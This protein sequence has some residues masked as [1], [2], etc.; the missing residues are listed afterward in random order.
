M[1]VS[2]LKKENDSLKHEITALKRNLEELQQSI[3]R[4]DPQVTSNG[5]EQ[6]THLITDAESLSTLEFYGKSYDDLWAESVN[7]LKHLWSRL[8]LMSSR[9]GKIGDLIEQLQRY[10]RMNR[11]SKLPPCISIFSKPLELKFQ[12]K[13]SILP[14]VSLPDLPLLALD[15]L[16]AN[17]QEDLW[18]SKKA[19]ANTIGL[20]S[21]GTFHSTKNSGMKFQVFHVTNGT[22]FSGWFEPSCPSPSR[23]NFRV[24]I[25]NKQG[26][27]IMADSLSILLALEL[28]N[29]YEVEISEV[30]DEDDDI[31]LF[32]VG[33]SYMRRNLN[34]V[35]DYFEG[36]IPLYF[37]YEFKGHFRMTRETC[38]LFTRAV[39]PTGRI[40]LGNGSG[41]AAIPPPKQV[42]AFLWCMANQEPARAVADRFD[43]TLSSVDRVLKGVSQAA[44]DLSGQF[45]RWPNGEFI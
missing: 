45:I 34:W 27:Q 16:S 6:P 22:V 15:Q 10:R 23:T 11:P 14:I 38:K 3:K 20:P 31:M 30:L 37:P 29:D 42:L 7:S 32:S 13:T 36:M 25:W 43:I 17:S 33:S 18:K 2:S 40:P 35:R 24:K 21:R 5:G 1:T 8:N 4:Q 12:I 39:M 26:N 9:V 41:R 28:L 19:S 44:I